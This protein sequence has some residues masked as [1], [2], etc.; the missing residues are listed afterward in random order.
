MHGRH[1]CRHARSLEESEVGTGTQPHLLVRNVALNPLL[2]PLLR[3]RS[4]FARALLFPA[5]RGAKLES[6]N[7]EGK[8]PAEVAEMNSQEAVVEMLKA[9]A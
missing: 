3:A 8:T 6:K 5:C 2:P 1:T 4:R 9:K 7:A